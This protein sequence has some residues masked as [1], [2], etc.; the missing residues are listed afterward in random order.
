MLALAW[1][2]CLPHL[3]GISL[4]SRND[5]FR[6]A[7]VDISVQMG[8]WRSMYETG[9]KRGIPLSAMNVMRKTIYP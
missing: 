5:N 8:C 2:Q 9:I 6:I 7:R 3:A 1:Y 4:G